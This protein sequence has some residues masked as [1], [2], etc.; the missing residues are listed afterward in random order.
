MIGIQSVR[1]RKAKYTLSQAK[2]KVRKM[3]FKTDVKPNPQYIHWR[4]FR[5]IQPDKFKPN[6]F[7]TKIINSD[8]HLIIGELK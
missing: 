6:S 4:A 5:Q 2:E 3:G 8:I 7:R 1:L